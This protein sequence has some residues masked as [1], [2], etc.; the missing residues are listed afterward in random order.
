[1]LS[2]K[3]MTEL[4][5]KLFDTTM[6]HWAVF[7]LTMSIYIR[8]KHIY[9]ADVTYKITIKIISGGVYNAHEILT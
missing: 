3:H 4:F 6:L 9:M 8:K 5:S 7:W 2:L 1:M